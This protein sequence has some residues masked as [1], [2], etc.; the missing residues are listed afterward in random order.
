MCIMAEITWWN[1]RSHAV[2]C[3]YCHDSSFVRHLHGDICTPGVVVM[4][5]RLGLSEAELVYWLCCAHCLLFV[6]PNYMHC[7]YSHIYIYIYIYKR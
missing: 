6:L 5:E 4:P 3:R 2:C 1:Y 7:F